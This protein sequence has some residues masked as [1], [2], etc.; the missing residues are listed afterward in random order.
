MGILAVCTAWCFM[1]Y[2]TWLPPWECKIRE[3]TLEKRGSPWSDNFFWAVHPYEVGHNFLFWLQF[4][5][6]VTTR[7]VLGRRHDFKTYFFFT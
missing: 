4:P 5:I 2:P 6:L 1:L 7:P 3:C